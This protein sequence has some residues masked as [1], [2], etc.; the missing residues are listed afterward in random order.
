MHGAGL[1]SNEQKSTTVF[2]PSAEI[3]YYPSQFDRRA[4]QPH[5]VTDARL[6][7][8]NAFGGLARQ[9]FDILN[10]QPSAFPY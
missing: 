8:R 6:P 10:I 5:N 2:D 4:A 3:L 1:A 9:L 7:R